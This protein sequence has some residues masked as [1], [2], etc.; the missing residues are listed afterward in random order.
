MKI[1]RA[2]CYV[3]ITTLIATTGAYYG[4]PY[5]S[6]DSDVV[7]SVVTIFSVF[8]GF[9]IATIAIIGDPRMIHEGSWR[10]A[11]ASREKMQQRLSWHITLLFIYLLTLAL[12]F[13]GVILEKA[14]PEKSVIRD[15]VDGAYLFFG[16]EGFL[17][18][19]ALP[20]ALRKMQQEMYDAEIERR[21]RIE[22][23]QS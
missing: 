10:I 8:A 13:A 5:V 18:T 19:F 15:I 22:G 3:A 20:L 17:L 6:N 16:I 12:L 9:L 14:L 1:P 23:I 2:A 11:E 7:I 4:H 21:R